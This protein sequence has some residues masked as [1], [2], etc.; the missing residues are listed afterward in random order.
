MFIYNPVFIVEIWQGKMAAQIL[1]VAIQPVSARLKTK[2]Q[3]MTT[4]SECWNHWQNRRLANKTFPQHKSS[5][6]NPNR[7]KLSLLLLKEITYNKASNDPIIKMAKIHF[8]NVL[9]NFLFTWMWFSGFTALYN[10]F[11]GNNVYS[12]LRWVDKWIS[13]K[14]CIVWHKCWSNRETQ[15]SSMAPFICPQEN[16]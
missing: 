8:N 3:P 10:N 9:Q 4:K 15:N 6:M 13:Y 12:M 2:V 1:V 7:S 14:H 16:W 11:Y 5:V